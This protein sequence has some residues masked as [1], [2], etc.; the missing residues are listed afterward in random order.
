MLHAV[1]DILTANGD[2]AMPAS[3]IMP[4]LAERGIALNHPCE[5]ARY[6]GFFG[7]ETRQTWHKS[8]GRNVKCYRSGDVYN[9]FEG[10]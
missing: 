6:L 5:L 7:V 10:A 3:A 4:V 8:V 1:G 9:A 2:V